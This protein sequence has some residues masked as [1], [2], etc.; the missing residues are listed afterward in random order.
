MKLIVL[1]SV[2]AVVFHDFQAIATDEA[3]TQADNEQNEVLLK[4]T[5]SSDEDSPYFFY[6]KPEYPKD[7][8]E[9]FQKCVDDSSNGVH[10]IQ[11]D[12]YPE[13]F[14]VYCNNTVDSGNWIVLQRRL[15][16][17]VDFNRDWNDYKQGFGFLH[18]EFWLGNEKLSYITNQRDHELRIDFVSKTG[19]PYF[20][21]YNLFR[22]SD[23]QSMYRLIGLGDYDA[24]STVG[25][26]AFRYNRGMPF[27]TR[28][29]DND[30]HSSS[31]CADLHRNGWWFDSCSWAYPNLPWGD[32]PY[33]LHFPGGNNNIRYIDM[34]IRPLL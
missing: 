32:S 3:V 12:G 8:H 9:V 13:P 6:Q 22:L 2:T 30:R 23:E 10:F 26:D 25:H 20:A 17:G 14:E 18:R 16:G 31:H 5:R 19:D 27:S 1:L 33:W 21:K 7:C 28:D 24:F 34:K 15:D 4:Q 11:P 29:R